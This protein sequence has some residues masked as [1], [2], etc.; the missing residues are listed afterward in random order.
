MDKVTFQNIYTQIEG[1]TAPFALYMD[2][3][4]VAYGNFEGSKLI[5]D[6]TNELIYHYKLSNKG[7]DI[8]I[9]PVVCEIFHFEV[10][11]YVQ[12]YFS[13]KD[14]LNSFINKIPVNEQDDKTA[15]LALY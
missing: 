10:V 14:H 7:S 11:Q 4:R 12:K 2:N 3:E 15:I 13:N 1:E 6:W 9:F 5:I 8:T